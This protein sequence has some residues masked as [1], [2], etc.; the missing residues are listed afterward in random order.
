MTRLSALWVV[1]LFLTFQS[2]VS[3]AI[4][5][6]LTGDRLTSDDLDQIG[7]LNFGGRAVWVLEGGREDSNG[8][9]PG[10]SSPISRRIRFVRTFAA[11]ASRS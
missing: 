11:V 4:R 3:P 9:I 7:R 6:G 1:T 8:R 10:M 5:L 2:P